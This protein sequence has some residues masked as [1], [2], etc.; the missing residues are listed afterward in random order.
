MQR[1]GF[2]PVRKIKGV[3]WE[4]KKIPELLIYEG[5][6]IYRRRQWL[7]LYLPYQYDKSSQWEMIPQCR[8]IAFFTPNLHAKSNV[9][10]PSPTAQP[11][12]H[13]STDSSERKTETQVLR[14][15]LQR[16]L[17]EWVEK[18][19]IETYILLRCI[20]K[21]FKEVGEKAKTEECTPCW[22]EGMDSKLWIRRG[23][24]KREYARFVCLEKQVFS[25][26]RH[27]AHHLREQIDRATRNHAEQ[28]RVHTQSRRQQSMLAGRIWC[29]LQHK[30]KRRSCT[31]SRAKWTLPWKIT[32]Q[33]RGGERGGWGECKQTHCSSFLRVFSRNRSQDPRASFWF[34]Q[35]D[36]LCY[37]MFILE[38]FLSPAL[39]PWGSERQIKKKS[40]FLDFVAL[41]LE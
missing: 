25:N 32:G 19:E 30:V 38:G 9:K 22:I 16:I 26:F 10:Y 37:G 31:F 4:R 7:A 39:R 15:I 6:T 41:P 1:E 33:E 13:L 34:P 3:S 5:G 23:E 8:E 40:R 17:G 28:S 36:L 14:R 35:L 27:A 21:L 11:I 2:E 24:R 29:E 18:W 12:A 20:L